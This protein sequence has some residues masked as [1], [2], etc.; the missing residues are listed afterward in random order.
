MPEAFGPDIDNYYSQIHPFVQ[1]FSER[2]PFFGQPSQTAKNL[3]S[4]REHL[5][6]VECVIIR[7][8][9]LKKMSL[10][11]LLTLMMHNLAKIQKQPPYL[12]ALPHTGTE[13]LLELMSD[14]LSKKTPYKLKD[15]EHLIKKTTN[16]KNKIESASSGFR[17]VR[18][19]I[20]LALAAVLSIIA[21]YSA[22]MCLAWVATMIPAV[23]M[24]GISL[25]LA[26][27]AI[28]ITLGLASTAISTLIG[29]IKLATS[30]IHE[31]KQTYT[32]RHSSAEQDQI[33]DE[34]LSILDALKE[35]LKEHINNPAENEKPSAKAA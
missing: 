35:K 9:C 11:D 12:M 10:N 29:S 33:M 20:K 18:A 1:S 19:S 16:V 17:Y 30:S 21:Y 34:Q 7:A 23:I 27:I 5:K 24:V 6:K 8:D 31:I 13:E 4:A 22:I 28:S 32:A 26:A 2:I 3:Q 25:N 15:L 14:L